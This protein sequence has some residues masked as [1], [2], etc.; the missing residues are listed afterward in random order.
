MRPDP[1][2]TLGRLGSTVLVVACGTLVYLAVARNVFALLAIVA[3]VA[4]VTL[5]L[6]WKR[7]QSLALLTAARSGEDIGT[8]ARA[9]DRRSP[10]FDPWV[11]RAVWDAMLP[12]V[13]LGD[14]HLPLRPSDRLIADLQIDADDLED[15]AVAVAVRVGRQ[16]SN[17]TGNAMSGTVSTVED[18]V[19]LVAL[20][21]RTEAA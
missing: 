1:A 18:L 6:N 4:I 12:Y 14:R 20:Q 8:F 3:S 5:H 7:N 16:S 9:F 21:P 19:R 17:W 13:R 15:L 11:I 2:P 10:D